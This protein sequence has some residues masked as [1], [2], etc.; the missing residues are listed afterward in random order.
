LE[1]LLIVISLFLLTPQERHNRVLF[2]RPQEKLY[3]NISLIP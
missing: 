3:Y 1:N 2:R